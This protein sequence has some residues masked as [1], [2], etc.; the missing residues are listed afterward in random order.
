MP[1]SALGG[2]FFMASAERHFFASQT[3]KRLK[4]VSIMNH[5]ALLAEFFANDRTYS[6]NYFAPR[7]LLS[8]LLFTTR[9][10]RT[11]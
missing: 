9:S 6:Q 2:G 7:S 3:S 5:F 8:I 4:S 10:W 11:T 1:A